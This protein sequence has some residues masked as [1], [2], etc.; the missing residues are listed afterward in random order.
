MTIPYS[1]SRAVC[2]GNGVTV[3]FPFSFRVWG[4][5]QIRVSL[6]SPRDE[7]SEA[8]G[9]SV[10]LTEEGGTVHYLHEGAPLPEGWL[11]SI[12]RDMP[13]VQET[14][15]ITG[16]RF[17]PQVIEDALD[18]ATAERQQ[19][20]EKVSRALVVSP[21]SQGSPQELVSNVTR[22]ANRASDAALAAAS[23]AEAAGQE[24]LAAAEK[25]QQAAQ[26]AEAAG[27]SAALVADATALAGRLDRLESRLAAAATGY[28]GEFR[29][30]FEQIPPPGWAIRNGAV[31]AEADTAYPDLWAALHEEGNAW[32][33]KT[34]EEWASLSEAAGGVGGVPFFVVDAE[35]R[36]IRLPDTRGDYERGAGSDFLPNVGDWHGDAVREVS[37]V[38]GFVDTTTSTPSGCFAKVT[39]RSNWGMGSGAG[40][41]SGQVNFV[42]GN[43]V[44]TASEARTRAIALL[45]CVFIGGIEPCA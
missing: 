34:A 27:A 19:L 11:L 44:P 9:W 3:D 20:L 4:A 30:F 6:T 14:D 32:K 7:T 40:S 16:A 21:T 42:L 5:D 10:S 33:C 13:F 28:P 17:D 1:A 41:S 24:A 37:G 15:L 23:S 36:S 31:L 35:A 18:K 25:A 39:N 29:N 43:A 8:S 45:P 38:V 22:A 2:Q 12:V 26:S